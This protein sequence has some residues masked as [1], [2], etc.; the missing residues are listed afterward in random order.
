MK[1]LQSLFLTFTIAPL[2]AGIDEDLIQAA[3]NGDI[4][5]VTELLEL[6]ADIHVQDWHGND[7]APIG[8]AAQ[9]GHT[10]TV[11]LLLDRG[12]NIDHVLI[13]SSSHGHIDT[14]K[15]L[16]ARGAN[17]HDDND[18]ALRYATKN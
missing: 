13:F 15:L 11:R 12:A 7:D 10:E 5:T 16:L 4:K 3:K 14:V 8:M 6:G 17:V 1:I 9:Y 2:F 18:S